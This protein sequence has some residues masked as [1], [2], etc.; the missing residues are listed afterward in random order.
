MRQQVRARLPRQTRRRHHSSTA[1]APKQP[2]RPS[3]LALNLSLDMPACRKPD[4]GRQEGPRAALEGGVVFGSRCEPASLAK[5]AVDTP[6]A[7]LRAA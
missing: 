4:E 2:P 3:P 7:V 6:C 1:A 5:R